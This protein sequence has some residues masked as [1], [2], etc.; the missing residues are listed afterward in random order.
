MASSQN[1][2]YGPV[3]K[4]GDN[5]YIFIQS[6]GEGIQGQAQ[7]VLHVQ[8]GEYGVRKISKEMQTI[9]E[10]KDSTAKNEYD[11]LEFLNGQAAHTTETPRIVTVHGSSKVA[12]HM[13]DAKGREQLY[14]PVLYLSYCNGEDADRILSGPYSVV[15]RM[16]AQLAHTLKF[17]YDNKILHRDLHVGNIFVHFPEGSRIPDFYIG[18]FGLASE[19]PDRPKYFIN[20]IQHLRDMARNLDLRK[21]TKAVVNELNQL[22]RNELEEKVGFPDLTRLLTLVDEAAA[23]RPVVDGDLSFIVG[24]TR[25]QQRYQTTVEGVHADHTHYGLGIVGPYQVGQITVD[26]DGNFQSLVSIG[27]Q[28][29][30]NPHQHPDFMS[31]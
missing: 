27:E 21:D 28:V 13:P 17:M 30:Q 4:D 6:L 3:F 16:I 24:P 12:V 19:T 26:A 15:L 5:E 22:M 23:N 25:V 31:E 11:T 14:M 7:L 2:M 1:I 20:D 29:F 9:D 8:S 10:I 18:D